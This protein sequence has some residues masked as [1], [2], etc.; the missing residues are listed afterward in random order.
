M[1]K[2]RGFFLPFLTQTLQ[3]HNPPSSP[4]PRRLKNFMMSLN[5]DKSTKYC[6]SVK[7]VTLFP[8]TCDK[9]QKRNN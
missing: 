5:V 2:L 6:Y 4:H 7:T 1:K 9:F 3:S 8:V